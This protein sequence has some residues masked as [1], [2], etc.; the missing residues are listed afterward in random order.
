MRQMSFPVS[1]RLKKTGSVCVLLIL[2]FLG[3][4]ILLTSKN[5]FLVLGIILGGVLAFFVTRRIPRLKG[6]LKDTFGGERK[7][8]VLL[9]VLFFLLLPLFLSRDAYTLHILIIAGIQIILIL[10]LNIQVGSTGLPNLGFA[11]FYGIGAYTSALLAVRLG[12]PFWAGMLAGGSVS[13]V[14]GLILG[15]PTLKTRT[16]YLALIT[17]AFGLVVYLL[18]LNLPFF[19]GPDGVRDIPPP[20]LFGWSLFSNLKI[21]GRNYPIQLNFYYLVFAFLLLAVLVAGLLH[22]SK[23]GLMWNAVR[24]DEIASQS[25][26]I[27]TSRVKLLAFSTGAF[28]AGVAGALYAHYIGYISAQNFTITQSLA[29]LSMV[30]LGGLDNI[31]GVVVAAFLLTILPE[32]FRA[33]TDYRII[34]YGV[35][36]IIMLIFRPAGLIPQRIRDYGFVLK[37]KG[38]K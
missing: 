7:T 18:F 21:F 23:V 8:A 22:N 28:Y 9:T 33:L 34:A 29:F 37:R 2:A 3:F 24:E 26:G 38:E 27:N 32:K 15:F 1:G 14:C 16:Y 5:N 11:A 19:D 20:R 4:F 25:V 35:I 17:I 30:I 36:I 12:V 31:M 13:A 6:G 10:G